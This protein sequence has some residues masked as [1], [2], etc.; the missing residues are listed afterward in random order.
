MAL[1]IWGWISYFGDIAYWIGF[2]VA[3]TIVYYFLD[4]REKKKISWVF[5]QLLLSG[6]VTYILVLVLK[7]IF[8][9]PRP[10]F[11]LPYCPSSYSFPSGHAAISFAWL[12]ALLMRP[13]R[14]KYL[15]L[16]PI[17]FLVAI[18]RIMLGVH[19][20]IDVV[21]G[22]VLG[23]L[24]SVFVVKTEKVWRELL[25]KIFSKK[26]KFVVRKIIHLSGILIVLSYFLLG[27]ETTLILTFIGLVVYFISEILRKM[28][29]HVPVIH[30]LTYFCGK[31]EEIRGI[32]TGPIFYLIGILLSLSFFPEICFLTGAI[33]L[34]VGDA[35][36]GLIGFK[37]GKHKW[38]YNKNKSIEG[39]L[40]FYLS[41]FP[42]FAIF[43]PI[44]YSLIL[45]F[46]AAVL[47]SF[48]SKGE[49]ILLPALVSGITC[50]IV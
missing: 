22:A 16:L 7:I 2:T 5:Y 20:W 24:V 6:Y 33:A 12:T 44:V 50:L 30:F 31:R 45:V 46:A 49:N 17:P 34:I 48:L 9:I 27:K 19:T 41:T 4:K 21:G 25:R 39:S 13:E 18:S 35:A 32:A 11:G 8:K 15:F 42:F 10:C 26:N 23:V 3:F 1:N 14:R 36:A 40:A 37:F 28:E 43:L 47:E 29:I 38:F